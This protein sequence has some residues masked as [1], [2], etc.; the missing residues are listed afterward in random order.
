MNLSKLALNNNRVTYMLLLLIVVMGLVGYQSLSR[1]SMP[2][3][4]VRVATV[5]TVFPGAGPE[6]VESLVSSKIEEVAQEI[7][8]VDFISSESRTGLS[9]ITIALQD[10]VKAKDLQPIWDRLRRKIDGI[11]KDL[12]SDISGPTVKDEDIGVV[13]G[14]I[15]GIE[16]DGYS[17]AEIKDY[18]DDLKNELIAL[19]DAAKV[20]IGGY[21]EE[22]IFVDFNDAELSK[23]GLSGRKLKDIISATNIIIPSGQVNLEDERISMEPT[24]NLESIQELQNILIPLSTKGK[25]IKLGDITDVKRD[26]VQT[27]ESIVRINGYEGISL[28]I[29]LKDGAN[30]IQLGEEV[31]KNI[32]S[33]NK[34]LPVGLRVKRIASQDGDVKSSISDFLINVLESV[35]IVLLVM[36]VFLGVR[37]GFVVASLI[38]FA[39]ISTLLFMGVFDVGINQVSL[40]ALIMALGM[41]VDNAIVVVESMV[42]RMENGE[43]SKDAAINTCQELMIPLLIS[44]LT[45]SAAFLAFFL[46]E[47]VMGEIMGPLFVVI[48]LAL[49]SS[50]FIALTVIPLFVIAFIKVN[51]N[52]KKKKNIVDKLNVYYNK[53]LSFSLRRP[54]VILSS[55]II[56]FVLS[57]IGFG[58]LP[59]VFMPDSERNLV[60]MDVNLPLGTKIE[61]TQENIDLIESYI[62]NELLVNDIRKHG[63]SDWSSFIGK[64]PKSYDLGYNPGE[65]NSGYAH[66]LLNTSSGEDNQSVIDSLE[67]F[68]F[69]NLPD[70]QITIK[71]LGSGGGA[72]IPVQVRLYGKEIPELY[73][74]VD[75]LKDK[76]HNIYGTK[77]IDDD[78]GPKIKKLVVKINQVKLSRAGLTNQDIALSLVAYLSGQTVGDYRE[79]DQTIPIVLKAE[80]NEN[81]HFEKLESLSIYSQSSGNSVP[82]S[83][84]ATVIP[85]WQ[86]AKILRRDLNRKITVN[87]QLLAGFTASDITD[88]IKPWIEEESKSWKPGYFYE[89]GGES[90]SSAKAMSAVEDKLPLAFFI[91]I[92]L[93]ILQFNSVRKTTI[94]LLT[95]PLGVIGVV[96]GLLLVGSNFSFTAFL[97]IISLAG[98]VINNAIVLI[99]RIQIEITSNNKEPLEAITSAANE[100][101][102]PIILTTFTTSLGLIPLWLGGGAMWE[103]MAIGIIFGLLFATVI[104]LL[105][106]PI[107]YKLLYR[108]R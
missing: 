5:V 37:T 55:I 96:A 39:I 44:S 63:I 15:L 27:R 98:I 12:P 34:R 17:N 32:I 13:Y 25:T 56:M 83:Q 100:R 77:N 88:I 49:I 101:F 61:I 28:C 53:I 68:C 42:V 23:Y 54:F 75:K 33:Y 47:S 16:S 103:P 6:R 79:K 59:F 92:F 3:Y 7:P 76:F 24:G 71:R 86:Y 107:A 43:A 105:F 51:K 84:V 1:N 89:F 91:I 93:L 2:P 85:E 82:L 11:R 20:E 26:Y 73:I 70:A 57:L 69:N 64:G 108:V 58:R 74:L 36:F 38:P 60:T 104:T 80:G 50:W 10:Y 94:V 31:D 14:I 95:I 81:D 4:T 97:G 18:A 65:A 45:T 87:C 19:D 22:R 35:L 66:I 9:V 72:A 102:R 8:E 99:D 21:V 40:A 46:A 48:S 29:S 52:K 90:E 78:W 41:L 62:R 106:V 67:N 30:I